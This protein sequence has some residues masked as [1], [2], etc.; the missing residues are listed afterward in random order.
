[1]R[2]DAGP[3]AVVGDGAANA[4]PAA[5]AGWGIGVRGWTG[6]LPMRAPVLDLLRAL[7]ALP[8]VAADDVLEI[9]Q[10]RAVQTGCFQGDAAGSAVTVGA[11]GSYQL[12]GT[13]KVPTNTTAFQIDS[14]DVTHDLGGFT[15]AGSN[16]CTGHP[17]TRCT[18]VNGNAGVSL[19]G[20]IDRASSGYPIS[21]NGGVSTGDNLCDGA[22]C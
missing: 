6:V 16:R 5:V 17:V 10:T 13:L 12:T 1:M 4:L 18:C 15:V 9:G 2:M 21:A 19:R 22:A 3:R 20:N 7:P 11:S 14:I 8:A